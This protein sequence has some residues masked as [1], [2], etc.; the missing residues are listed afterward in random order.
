[1]TLLDADN[2]FEVLAG[3]ASIAEV[4]EVA[5]DVHLYVLNP[6]DSGSAEAVAELLA[7]EV[8]VVVTASD[9]RHQRVASWVH[10]AIAVLPV[11]TDVEELPGTIWD[12]LENP[13][14]MD[15]GLA[16]D[17]LRGSRELGLDLSPEDERLLDGIADRAMLPKALNAVAANSKTAA[18]RERLARSGQ[19]KPYLVAAPQA[20]AVA[21]MAVES[22]LTPDALP[23]EI[24]KLSSR[25]RRVIELYADA[26]TY[27]E[28]AVKLSI[29]QLT[30]R[31][32]IRN[33]LQK[34]DVPTATEAAR[35]WVALWV[36]GRHP[37]PARLKER[38]SQLGDQRHHPP[39]Y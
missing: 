22:T 6:T 16:G 24:L 23:P 13:G 20:L 17:I 36:T 27:E 18:L 29:S 14:R 39:R 12:A 7:A 19:W 31:N 32:H 25:E 26:H 10:G 11:D 34:L 8:V 2:R 33:A 1:M 3:C 37:S 15:A 5:D 38:I 4:G 30:V 28:I 21:P 35:I 9:P